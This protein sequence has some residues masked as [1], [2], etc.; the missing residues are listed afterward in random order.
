MKSDVEEEGQHDAH[1]PTISGIGFDPGE[2]PRAMA[3]ISARRMKIAA[4]PDPIGA[5]A[6]TTVARSSAICS[7]VM[8]ASETGPSASA[9]AHGGRGGG[10]LRGGAFGHGGVPRFLTMQLD[11]RRL[12]LLADIGPEACALALL[13][14]IGEEDRLAADQPA[15]GGDTDP[16]QERRGHARNH[17]SA[18]LR[19]TGSTLLRRQAPPA[20]PW[21]G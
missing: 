2:T 10:F 9:L 1:P 4:T 3:R 13:R 12:A 21:P 6:A 20:A 15:A 19:V 18:S 17:V 11:H 7:S 16:D 5:A 14:R 8:S